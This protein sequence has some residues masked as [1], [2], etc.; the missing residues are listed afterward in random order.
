MFKALEYFK[1]VFLGFL[2]KLKIFH[3]FSYFHKFIFQGIS[4]AIWGVNG[5]E[6][7]L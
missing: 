3:R 2:R 7:S 5:V 4:D 1:G 6:D